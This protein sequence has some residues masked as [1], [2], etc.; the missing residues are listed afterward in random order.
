M[1][2]LTHLPDMHF[3][4]TGVASWLISMLRTERLS[5]TPPAISKNMF[6]NPDVMEGVEKRESKSNNSGAW[7][8]A[9][10]VMGRKAN[11]A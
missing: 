4:N 8:A 6:C 5:Q 3:L 2:H 10:R 1:R 11:A 9:G 7:T